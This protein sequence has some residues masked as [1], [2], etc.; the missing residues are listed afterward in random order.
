MGGNPGSPTVALDDR[1]GMVVAWRWSNGAYRVVQAASRAP[2]GSWSEPVVVSA[3]S[4]NASRPRLAVDGEGH[5]IAG[6]IQSNGDW[7]VAQVASRGADGTWEQPVSF[8][9]EASNGV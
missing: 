8:P 6:W 3:P 1:G 4:R 9:G 2:E 5:A 7:T